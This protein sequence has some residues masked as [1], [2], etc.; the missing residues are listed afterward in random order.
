MHDLNVLTD[1]DLEAEC[2]RQQAILN[3]MKPEEIASVAPNA[4]AIR[5]N[6]IAILLNR[7]HMAVRRRMRELTV[8]SRARDQIG[9]SKN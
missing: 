9:P 8:Q 6:C 1:A 5:D 7:R 2:A 3:N 4:M